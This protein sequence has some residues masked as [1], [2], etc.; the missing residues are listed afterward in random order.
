MD[1]V[2]RIA[3][4]HDDVYGARLVRVVQCRL[5]AGAR[6]GHA[7]PRLVRQEGL[8]RTVNRLQLVI[9]LLEGNEPSNSWADG[10]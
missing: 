5:A 6:K 4:Q 10:S 2:G 1:A 9:A 8:W 3:A 7:P